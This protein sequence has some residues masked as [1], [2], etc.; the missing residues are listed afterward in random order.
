MRYVKNVKSTK[1]AK[2]L[3]A[4]IEKL[5]QATTCAVKRL[6]QAIGLPLTQK[7]SAI[8]VSWG[9]YSAVDWANDPL[10]ANYLVLNNYRG[11]LRSS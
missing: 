11:L 1:L 8:A 10:F 4:I 9:N 2:V 5:Q 6:V 3:M 7:I